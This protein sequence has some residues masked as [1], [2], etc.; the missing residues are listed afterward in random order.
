MKQ[1]KSYYILGITGG[2]GSGKT[3]VVE[4]IKKMAP[5]CFLH[6]DAI[7]HE[8][9]EPGGASYDALLKE[10]GEDILEKD[11][12]ESEQRRISRP[13]L[14]AIAMATETTRR[15]LNEVTHPLVK[16]AVEDKL[17][18]LQREKFQGIAVV[19]AA[20]L[21]EAGYQ[22]ICDALWYVHAPESDR[23]RRMKENRGYSEEK[24]EHIIAGQLS[25]EEFLCR[26]DAVIENPDGEEAKLEEQIK[27]HLKEQLETVCK[28]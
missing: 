13:N 26:A 28:M 8:L 3:T 6:C 23:R 16:Q 9:M 4:K 11:C 20:L 27:T 22:E 7:A 21:I 19:E 10:F 15:R 14:A 24:I 12:P 17:Q 5:V 18:Q 1:N 25:E 2:A